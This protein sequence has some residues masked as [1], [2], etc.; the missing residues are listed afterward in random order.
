MDERRTASC[1]H[2]ADAAEWIRDFE[3]AARRTL[4]QRLDYG[5]VRTEKPVMDAA[6]FRAF[7]TTAAYRRWC[8][9]SLPSWLGFGRGV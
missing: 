8:E 9:E 5:F 7:A 2:A 4:R 6:R 3:A 1:G